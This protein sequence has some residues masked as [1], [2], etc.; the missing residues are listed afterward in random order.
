MS[1][2]AKRANFEED[3]IEPI[4]NLTLFSICWLARSPLPPA[5][6]NMRFARRSVIYLT[7]AVGLAVDYAAHIGHCFMLKEGDN[8]SER[9]IDALADIGSPVLNGAISTFLAVVVLGASKR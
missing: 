5:P 2:R 3:E 6:L 1:E 7:L 4:R 8:R 9:V